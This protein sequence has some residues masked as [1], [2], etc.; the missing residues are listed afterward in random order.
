MTVPDCG[1]DNALVMNRHQRLQGGPRRAWEDVRKHE[2]TQVGTCLLRAL[3]THAARAP[4]GTQS[5]P[6]PQ[7]QWAT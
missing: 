6:C 3:G 5:L 4:P 1:H 2:A 7:L